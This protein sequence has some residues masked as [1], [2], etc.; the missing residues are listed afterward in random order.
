[1]FFHATAINKVDYTFG[2]DSPIAYALRLVVGKTGNVGV[3]M[4]LFLS[5]ICLYFSFVRNPDAYAFMKKRFARIVIPVWIVNGVYWIVQ[6]EVIVHVGW[7]TYLAKMTLLDFWLTGNQSVWFVSL[8]AVLY[9][10]YPLIYSF[11]FVPEE[12]GLVLF[13]GAVLLVCAFSISLCVRTVNPDAYAMTEIALTRVPVFVFGCILGR[14][15]YEGRRVSWLWVIPIALSVVLL[16]SNNAVGL[17]KNPSTRFVM[18][19]GGVGLT[20]LFAAFFWVID[21]LS[22]KHR[23]FL[24]RFLSF[25]GGFSLELYLCHITLNQILRVLPIYQQGDFLLYAL[26]LA[27]AFVCAWLVSKLTNFVSS[28]LLKKKHLAAASV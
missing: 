3:D 24:L 4:F 14:F 26:M 9:L 23:S 5:G 27:V 18:G 22:K 16:F 13:R 8:I 11:L 6:N 10:C 28:R 20:Y 2:S 25:A 7:W 15:V 1:M 12:D 19:V 21:T 17:F